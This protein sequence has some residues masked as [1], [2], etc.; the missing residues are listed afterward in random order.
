MEQ[1]QKAEIM[2]RDIVILPFPF[3]DNDG[4]K[5]RPAIIVSN[6]IF[7]ESRT[8]RIMV[9]LTSVVKDD[10]FSIQISQN[11]LVEGELLKDS[12]ARAD[13]IF[14][15]DKERII[16]KIGRIDNILFEEIRTKIH[17]LF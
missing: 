7:N 14:C 13:R 4:Y 9:P 15:I 2:Q 17:A 6:E 11:D 10:E 3:T 16:T 12:R 8:D 1:I 5:V